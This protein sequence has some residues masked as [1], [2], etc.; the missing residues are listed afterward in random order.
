M[1]T[2]INRYKR[3]LDLLLAV[4]FNNPEVVGHADMPDRCDH[5]LE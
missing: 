2:L 5:G 3:R 1:K 4:L